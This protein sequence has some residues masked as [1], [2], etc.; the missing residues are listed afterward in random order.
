MKHLLSILLLLAWLQGAGRMGNT[1]KSHRFFHLSFFFT[2]YPFTFST[3]LRTFA[4]QCPDGGIG[5]HE[6]LKIPWPVM[7][8]RVRFPFRAPARRLCQNEWHSPFFALT[9]NC[10]NYT[11]YST[12]V[13]QL[14]INSC[15]S[16]NSW[17]GNFFIVLTHPLFFCSIQ[18]FIQGEMEG[19][20]GLF[21]N[22]ASGRGLHAGFLPH[23]I[24]PLWQ[25]T[26]ST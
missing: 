24:S 25:T 26:I 10:T 8:V 12:A 13:C 9:T 5:R 1:V 6:G 22:F 18:F 16:C 4:P 21:R 23:A 14:I 17:F 2:L 19:F 3:F 11:N 20:C 7:A 15:N